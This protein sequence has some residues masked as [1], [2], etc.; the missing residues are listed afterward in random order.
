MR[1]AGKLANLAGVPGIVRDGEYE[2]AALSIGIAVR[3]GEFHTVITVNGT[4]IYFHRLTGSI[5]GVSAG[6]P[7]RSPISSGA[8]AESIVERL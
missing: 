7:S 8:S 6:E 2:S 1:W 4:D 3:R 5:T